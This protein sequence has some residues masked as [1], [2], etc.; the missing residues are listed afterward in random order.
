M[1]R[2]PVYTHA[3]FASVSDKYYDELLSRSPVTATWLGEHSYDGIL[4]EIGAE[5]VA[6]EISF[7]RN[8][9]DAFSSLPERELSLDER[10]DREIAIHFTT[11]HLFMKED[12]QRWKLGKDLAMDIGDS[13]FLLFVRNFAPLHERVESM[14]SR[15]KATPIFLMSGKTLF[16][17]VPLLWGEIYLESAKNLPALLDTIENSIE[18]YVPEVLITKFRKASLRA[19]KAIGN[20]SNWLKQAIMPN[21]TSEWAL[22]DAAFGA[23]LKVRK[24]GLS[25]NEMLDVGNSSLRIAKDK[26]NLF[27]RKILGISGRGTETTKDEA[28]NK[29][30]THCPANF[31]MALVAY[32]DAV[33]R[34]REFIRQSKFATLPENEELEVIET[35]SFMSHVVPFA[36]YIGPDRTS[37]HQRGTYLVTRSQHN[38]DLGRYNYANISNFSIH[39]G[40]PG[41]HLQLCGHNLHPSKMRTFSESDEL[42]EGW[43]NYCEQVIKE[44]GFENSDE[45][46][47][48]QANNEVFKAAR[49]MI[50]INIHTKVWTFDKGCQFLMETTKMDKF[51]ALAEMKR[52]TQ[53]P[54][55]QLSHLIGKHLIKEMKQNLKQEYK[56]DYSDLKFHDLIIYQ[57]NMPIFLGKDYYP[58]M[59]KADFEAKN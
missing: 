23:M 39:E 28:F 59:M 40:Y 30:R 58:K 13:I 15:L 1:R 50:D 10:L 4:P 48:I 9:K 2:K 11:Q 34:G 43:A 36:A 6:K 29:I 17:K 51:S 42:V 57:G 7:L 54:G 52:Y 21:A 45:N 53:T 44:Y 47:L 8:M 35:P 56:S 49:V 41:H 22:G 24:L 18:G 26:E 37:K 33:A 27:A 46:Y 5:A 12:L 32:K 14:I 16:Q 20:Y 31:E 19:K 55:Y 38:S 3:G 25:K